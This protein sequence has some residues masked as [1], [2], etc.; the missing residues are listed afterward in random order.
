MG[1]QPPSPLAGKR[2]V[3]TRAEAQSATL[4]AALRAHGAEVISLPLI[5]ILPPL[6]YA[7]LDRALRDLAK[8]DWL[9]FTSQNAVTGVCDRLAVLLNATE[10]PA[11]VIPSVASNLSWS[12]NHATPGSLRIAAVG[13]ATAEAAQLAGFNVTHVGQ[14]GTAATLVYELAS[15]IARETRTS[16]EKRSRRRRAGPAP[17]EIRRRS[18]RSHRISH[19]RHYGS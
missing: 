16:S 9:I 19:F 8:F 15:R 12:A 4:A 13:K 6:D 10:A 1:D 14:A 18:Q 3:I 5:Q 7:A 17:A 2:V 11:P